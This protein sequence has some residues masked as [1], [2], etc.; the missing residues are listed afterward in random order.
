MNNLSWF[1]WSG[2]KDSALALY[3]VLQQGQYKVGH[4]LT[5]VNAVHDR[6]S[7]HG[8]RRTLLLAQADSLGIPLTTIELPEQP[9]MNE[10]ESAMMQKVV[11]LKTAGCSYAIF[12]DIFLED[13]KLY[14]EQNLSTLGVQCVFPIWKNN[15]TKLVYEFTD[16][17]F[18]AI[19]VCVNESYLD[20]NFCGRIIDRKFVND[21]PSNVDPCGENGEFHSFV[22]D[23]P[24]FKT[25]VNFK[26]GEIVR[27]TYAAPD[28]SQAGYGFYFCDLVP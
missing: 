5:N 14:R 7:M 8:V 12:G 17:G 15:T 28:K 21:L 16:L 11:E 24:I 3:K 20:K 13:L 18:K 25:P 9:G 23:G 19:V 26:K 4:L 6:V 2:G 22:F 27:R 1:N 10:Y